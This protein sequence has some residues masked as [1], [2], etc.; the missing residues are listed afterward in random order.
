MKNTFLFSL[1]VGIYAVLSPCTLQATTVVYQ[2]GFEAPEFQLGNLA[3]QNG[4]TSGNNSYEADAKIVSGSGG[5][6]VQISA[7]A[8]TYCIFSKSLTNYNP[9]AS[10]RADHASVSLQI[11]T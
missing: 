9:V 10:G 5:Q 8:S 1:F 7:P 3:G 6:E 2:T 11:V 4:W